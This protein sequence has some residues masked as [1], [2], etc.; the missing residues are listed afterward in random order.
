MSTTSIDL[1]FPPIKSIVIYGL[2][3]IRNHISFYELG[4]RLYYWFNNNNNINLNRVFCAFICNFLFFIS[5]ESI[6]FLEFDI[7]VNAIAS[8]SVFLLNQKNQK[9]LQL[10]LIHPTHFFRASN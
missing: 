8:V 6:I 4:E 7:N 3:F 5:F 2:V 9:K 10:H 1:Q